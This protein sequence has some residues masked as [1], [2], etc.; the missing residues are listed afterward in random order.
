MITADHSRRLGYSRTNRVGH[1][2]Q[3]T[4]IQRRES[5]AGKALVRDGAFSPVTQGTKRDRNEGKNRGTVEWCNRVPLVLAQPRGQGFT[6]RY[7]MQ[8]DPVTGEYR[9]SVSLCRSSA[10]GQHGHLMPLLTG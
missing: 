8:L 7:S 9:Q 10:A 6:D 5:G 3:T 4:H 1:G 2:N